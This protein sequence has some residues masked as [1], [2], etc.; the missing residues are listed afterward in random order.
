MG[1]AT[2]YQKHRTLQI[3]LTRS[4]GSDVC[5]VL[6]DQVMGCKLRNQVPVNGGLNLEG[7]K[8]AKFL[9]G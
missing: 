8:V 5:P 4:I 1:V 3:G 6:E 9:V 7:P 2:V